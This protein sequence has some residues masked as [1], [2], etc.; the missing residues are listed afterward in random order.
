M[1]YKGLVAALAAASV[2]L[3]GTAGA[4]PVAAE[5]PTI[6]VSEDDAAAVTSTTTGALT[7]FTVTPN[8]VKLSVPDV[9]VYLVDSGGFEAGYGRTSPAGRI[10][11][12]RVPAGTYSVRAWPG[13][14]VY[15]D[16]LRTKVIVTAGHH[17]FVVAVMRHGATIE[18]RAQ[19]ASGADLS[20]ALVVGRDH[21]EVRGHGAAHHHLPTVMTKTG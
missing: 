7:V 21:R 3:F 17:E 19:I 20:N 14:G 10:T 6:T 9:P 11:F 5:S 13:P 1:R 8:K 15:L 18:G 2:L 4:G 16:H 12:S